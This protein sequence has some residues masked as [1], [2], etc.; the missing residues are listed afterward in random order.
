MTNMDREWLD[1]VA[2]G[3]EEAFYL[4][5]TE[6]HT[7]LRPFVR[8]LLHSAFAEEEVLQET[9]IRV[10]LHRDELPAIQNLNA[11]M[12]RV[13][14]RECL[15]YIRRQDS[16]GRRLDRLADR[17]AAG[18]ETPEERLDADEIG[19]V[20]RA[21]IDQM[22]E[23]RRQIFRMSRDQGLKPAEIAR[24]LSLSVATVKNILSQ[25]LRD[26]R[27]RL[28]LPAGLFLVLLRVIFGKN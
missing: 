8:R 22:P 10:W 13:A 23:R 11:W 21:T 1:R 24:E 12:F 25:A 19:R 3:D 26:I 16:E 5:F 6:Y 15:S 17:P 20:I 27:E 9:F 18:P 4:L 2:E 7:R 28:G 14:S